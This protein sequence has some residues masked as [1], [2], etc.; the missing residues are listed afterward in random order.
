MDKHEGIKTLVTAREFETRMK[1]ISQE[2]DVE[3]RHI[4][5]DKL[6]CDALTSLGYEAGVNIFTNMELWYS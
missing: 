1:K 5:A 3:M 4:H 6:L 2:E